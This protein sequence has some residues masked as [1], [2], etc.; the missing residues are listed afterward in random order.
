MALLVLG[1]F[2]PFNISMNGSSRL[3]PVGRYD[4]YK[5]AGKMESK[6]TEYPLRDCD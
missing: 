5:S 2:D 4:A 1:K 6:S 3:N